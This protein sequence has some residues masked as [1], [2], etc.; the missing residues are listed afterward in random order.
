MPD[1]VLTRVADC[2]ATLTINLLTEDSAEGLQAFR[3]KREPN[4]RRSQ[5]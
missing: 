3:E 4:F 1:E 5:G 2:V